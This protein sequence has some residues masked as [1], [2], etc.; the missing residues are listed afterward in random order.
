MIINI[1]DVKMGNNNYIPL[2]Q[3]TIELSMKQGFTYIG[4]YD[5][6]MSRAVGLDTNSVKNNW[7]DT[8]SHTQ[9][10]TEPLLTFKKEI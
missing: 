5:M 9:Y 2:E 7:Y 4:R 1:A 6:V 10:K 3:D 8:T